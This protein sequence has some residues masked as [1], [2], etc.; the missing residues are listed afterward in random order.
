MRK[1]YIFVCFGV[2]DIKFQIKIKQIWKIAIQ[3]YVF[4]Q[5][6]PVNG[7][8]STEVKENSLKKLKIT[9]FFKLKPKSKL[10]TRTKNFTVQ[11]RIQVPNLR[12]INP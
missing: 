10:I 4:F 3:M 9:N 6:R 7:L 8:Y 1:I 5:V 2:F 11:F 12:K